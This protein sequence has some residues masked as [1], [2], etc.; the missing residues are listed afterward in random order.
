MLDLIR[1]PCRLSNPFVP[2]RLN[3]ATE[4]DRYG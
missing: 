4:L 1:L 3:E 2:L